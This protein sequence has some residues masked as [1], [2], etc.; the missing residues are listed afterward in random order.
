[1]IEGPLGPSDRY[2][3]RWFFT[4]HN[5]LFHVTLVRRKSLNKTHALPLFLMKGEH[6][7]I[8]EAGRKLILILHFSIHAGTLPGQINK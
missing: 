6:T 8:R 4:T 3:K 2:T 5:P 7:E 1:M